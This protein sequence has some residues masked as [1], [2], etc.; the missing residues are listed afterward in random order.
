[1]PIAQSIAGM[2][3][4]QFSFRG[5]FLCMGHRENS[6]LTDHRKAKHLGAA[7]DAPRNSRLA[8]MLK[9]QWVVTRLGSGL[10]GP[11]FE[12]LASSK[13]AGP[14]FIKRRAGKK[15]TYGYSSL[16]CRRYGCFR[17]QPSLRKLVLDVR[18]TACGARF[19]PFGTAAYLRFGSWRLLSVNRKFEVTT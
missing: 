11:D 9:N 15:V 12:I 18:R 16:V 14:A 2:Q 1:V 4:W 3:N 19:R 6:R 5:I 17:A 7:H 10:S 8:G 13:R